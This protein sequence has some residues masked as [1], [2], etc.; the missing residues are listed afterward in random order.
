MTESYFPGANALSKIKI[1]FISDRARCFL[2]REAFSLSVCAHILFLGNA[3]Q[4]QTLSQLSY[5]KR[6]L[7]RCCSAQQVIQVRNGKGQTPLIPEAAQYGKQRNGIRPPGNTGNNVV[8]GAEHVIF[9][10]GL[11]NFINNHC[12]KGLYL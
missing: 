12:F 3:R 7:L 4:P 6:I 1:K 8:S 5:K 11:D 2:K 9:F 10:N